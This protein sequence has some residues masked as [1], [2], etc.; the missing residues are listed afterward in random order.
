MFGLTNTTMFVLVR[1]YC[2]NNSSN[3]LS[4]WWGS[5]CFIS[6]VLDTAYT[7]PHISSW[8]RA[9]ELPDHEATSEER[10]PELTVHKEFVL[11]PL[12]LGL[13][14][15]LLRSLDRRGSV[16][17]DV[18]AESAQEVRKRNK[19]IT[20]PWQGG[21]RRS[22][23]L[24]LQTEDIKQLLLP[25]THTYVVY[26]SQW[27]KNQILL[28]SFLDIYRWEGCVIFHTSPWAKGPTSMTSSWHY[29]IMNYV[30]SI[31]AH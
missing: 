7:F 15:F 28:C 9:S 21:M 24:Q 2:N 31:F 4:A 19:K 16:C 25:H 8:K 20:Q 3:H 29:I 5:F 11:S 23:R 1:V 10:L 17:E 30:S 27:S 22:I 18:A 12:S 6:P 14:L 26:C 13:F